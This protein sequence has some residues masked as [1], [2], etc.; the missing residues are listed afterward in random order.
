MLNRQ[1]NI[2]GYMHLLIHTVKQPDLWNKLIEISKQGIE[3]IKNDFSN[4]IRTLPT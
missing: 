2:C 1:K 3:K 4:K